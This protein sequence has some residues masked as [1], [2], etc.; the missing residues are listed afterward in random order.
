MENH[1]RHDRNCP[2]SLNV[3]TQFFSHWRITL[4][5]TNAQKLIGYFSTMQIK[6][7]AMSQIY[8]ISNLSL[9]LNFLLLSTPL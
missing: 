7:Q 1:H 5:Y 2:H 4:L 3:G 8:K 6:D 9:Y